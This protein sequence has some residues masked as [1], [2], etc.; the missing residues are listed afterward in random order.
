V[1]CPNCANTFPAAGATVYCATC[2]LA[3]AVTSAGTTTFTVALADL[4]VFLLVAVT[5]TSRHK[6]TTV[7][8]A[9]FLFS[10]RILSEAGK[11]RKKISRVKHGGSRIL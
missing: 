5:V 9:I 3:A 2:T 7:T 6:P 8:L 1:S 11:P 10:E 4:V